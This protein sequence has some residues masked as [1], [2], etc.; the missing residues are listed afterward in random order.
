MYSLCFLALSAVSSA[1][2][3]ELNSD[4]NGLSS[5]EA[6]IFSLI[7][8]SLSLSYCVFFLMYALPHNHEV[9]HAHIMGNSL[10]GRAATFCGISHSDPDII[11]GENAHGIPPERSPL[12]PLNGLI[13]HRS[14]HR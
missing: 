8:S 3:G 1:M 7:S 4:A 10:L 12:V 5:P 2:W 6:V 11:Y 14:D 9:R 13:S